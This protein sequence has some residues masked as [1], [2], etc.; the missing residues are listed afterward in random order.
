[1]DITGIIQF[2]KPATQEIPMEENGNC[3]DLDFCCQRAKLYAGIKPTALCSAFNKENLIEFS[4]DFVHYLYMQSNPNP[5]L[6]SHT[7]L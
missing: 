6:L 1:M 7:S 2:V 3:K 5:V 4:L